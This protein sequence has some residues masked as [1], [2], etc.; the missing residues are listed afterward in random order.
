MPELSL[1]AK[2]MGIHLKTVQFRRKRIQEILG[3]NLGD[4]DTRLTLSIAVRLSRLKSR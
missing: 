4:A 3:V 1:V 2:S